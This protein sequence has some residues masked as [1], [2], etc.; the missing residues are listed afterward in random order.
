MR[1]ATAKGW[2]VFVHVDEDDE[3]KTVYE[4]HT[5]DADFDHEPRGRTIL[6]DA[7]ASKGFVTSGLTLDELESLMSES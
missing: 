3:T 5:P 7:G 1:T 2:L 4:L 6:T